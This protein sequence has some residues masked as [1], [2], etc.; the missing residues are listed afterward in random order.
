MTDTSKSQG[1]A[2]KAAPTKAAPKEPPK[3]TAG[4]ERMGDEETV[5]WIT[6]NR[7]EE[8]TVGALHRAFRQA[9]Y[10]ANL[11]RFTRLVEPAGGAATKAVSQ[12]AAKQAARRRQPSGSRT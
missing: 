7:T 10:G 11:R 9:G 2:V 1:G 3:T 4:R 12:A 5:A 6:A 8:Q